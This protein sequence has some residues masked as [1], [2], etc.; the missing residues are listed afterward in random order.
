MNGQFYGDGDSIEVE[1]YIFPKTEGNYKGSNVLPFSLPID[2]PAHVSFDS[3]VITPTPGVAMKCKTLKDAKKLFVNVCH[4]KDVPI[5]PLAEC[6][7]IVGSRS[8]EN[9][10]MLVYD[11]VIHSH[12]WSAMLPVDADNTKK[13]FNKVILR[14]YKKYSLFPFNLWFS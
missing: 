6:F 14:L 13:Y 11:V 8:Q 10:S 1:H 5:Y 4:H 2:M 3:I 7:V 12:V 9:E